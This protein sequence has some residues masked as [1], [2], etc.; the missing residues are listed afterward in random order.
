MQTVEYPEFN[1]VLTRDNI[2]KLVCLVGASGTGKTTVAKKLAEQ[3]YNVIQSYTTR[4]PRSDDEW[5]HIFTDE[6]MYKRHKQQGLIIAETLFDGH[7]YWATKEQYRGYDVSIYVID[8]Y[9]ASQLQYTV[10]GVRIITIALYASASVRIE[11]MLKRANA[12]TQDDINK[13][14]KRYA[15]DL[16][17]FNCIKC[18]YVINAD[19]AIDNIVDDIHNIIVLECY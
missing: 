7:Y 12:M 16:D 18:D 6:T 3:W 4:P 15:H 1:S 13:V 17:Q 11:R 9:G 10:F 2:P 5:G 8:P 14:Y 19:R